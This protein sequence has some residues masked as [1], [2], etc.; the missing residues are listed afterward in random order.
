M[1][2][3]IEFLIIIPTYNS[4]KNLRKFTSSIKSQSHKKWRTIFIDA[5]SSKP[6]KDW[7]KNCVEL[8]NRFSIIDELE[9]FKGIYP[10]M[11]LG[12]KFAKK[13][14]WV[15]FFGSDDWFSSPESLSQIALNI[16]NN[17]NLNPKLLICGSQFI[18]KKSKKG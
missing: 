18:D 15:I 7:L 12:A 6:H 13:K 1:L 17:K 8:D 2:N 14:E 9:D 5:D 10:S 16:I 3:D 11:S 4:Y